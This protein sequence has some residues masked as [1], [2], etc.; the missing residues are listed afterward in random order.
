M[1]KPRKPPIV[2]SLELAHLDLKLW[3][4]V[5]QI[6][7]EGKYR[8]WDILRHLS[9]PKRL[10]KET[11]WAAIKLHRMSLARSIPLIGV[12][13]LPF[14]YSVPEKVTKQ[15]HQIDLAVGQEI[16]I[17]KQSTPLKSTA[18]ATLL[19]MIRREKTF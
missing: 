15:L 3:E 2:N 12:D 13:Q 19:L 6:E 18:G 14:S 4:Q 11:W 9:P 7:A 17:L 8:H 5:L 1:K 10:T 16:N